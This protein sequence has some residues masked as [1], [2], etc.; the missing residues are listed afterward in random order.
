MSEIKDYKFLVIDSVSHDAIL[1]NSYKSIEDFLDANCIHKLSHNTIRQR[2]LDNKY[3]CFEDVI[4]K[5]LIWE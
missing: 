4:I 3:F 5:K 2:L 1:L